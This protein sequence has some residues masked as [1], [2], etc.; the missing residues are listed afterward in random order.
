TGELKQ[1]GRVQRARAQQ[2]FPPPIDAQHSALISAQRQA[3]GALAAEI[4]LMDLDAGADVEIR[5]AA[6]RIEKCPGRAPTAT[7][8]YCSRLV[9]DRRIGGGID[10]ADSWH[11][12]LPRG[13][14]DCL[15]KRIA[16]R[17]HR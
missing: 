1:F 6:R 14:D 2:P 4:D 17:M 3:A 16:C 10:I 13:L 7:A 8:P 11:A 5:P 9:A 15:T 12:A